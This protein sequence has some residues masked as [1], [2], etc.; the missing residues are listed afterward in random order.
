M[1]RDPLLDLATFEAA[2]ARI[3]GL[4]RPTPLARMRAGPPSL[5][6]ADSRR[7]LLELPVTPFAPGLRLPSGEPPVGLRR[8]VFAKLE[9]L[10]VTGSFKARGAV[11]RVLALD[12]VAGIVT[13]SGGN[14]GLAVAYAG[15]CVGAE[16][17]VFLPSRT[18]E[19][20]ARR[21][22]RWGATVV[23]VGDVWDDAH[24]A[25]VEHAR[26]SGQTYVHPFADD[27]VIAGQGT[28]ALEVLTAAPEI[29]L[30][31]VAI[32]GGGLVAGVATA[33]KLLRPDLRVVGVE[34]TGAP[35]LLESVR[36][37]RVI[38]LSEI[39]TAAS[40]LAPRSTHPRNLELVRRFVDDIVLVTD[41]EM[42]EAARFLLREAG[43]GA[44]LS[45]AAALAAVL[46]DRIGL[47]ERTAKNPCILVCGAGSD[48]IAEAPP[49]NSV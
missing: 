41:D 17:T 15:R 12:D 23:R 40:T 29:D 30:L 19:A 5:G 21:I 48:A 24:E 47:D 20:K 27:E 49:Q 32:G 34:P 3:A 2:Q 14:H 6:G 9:T 36:A 42:R 33:A 43:I 35:T 38:S 28:I 13:A 44:E 25:A 45:G 37:G 8:D 16:T 1:Q 26:S 39:R 4:V 22:E 10:Q 46:Y 31:V 11:N 7:G 18:S